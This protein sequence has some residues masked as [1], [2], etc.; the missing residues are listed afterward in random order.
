MPDIKREDV[1]KLRAKQHQKIV[2]LKAVASK[3]LSKYEI[4]DAY[5]Q[6]RLV[7]GF[8]ADLTTLLESKL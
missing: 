4:E 7:E 6:M 3:S 2:S 1:E 5:D 8:I